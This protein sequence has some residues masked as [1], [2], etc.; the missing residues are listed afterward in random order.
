MYDL[1]ISKIALQLQEE[2]APKFDN[3]F[4]GLGGF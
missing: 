2:E 3:I 1:G 4:V